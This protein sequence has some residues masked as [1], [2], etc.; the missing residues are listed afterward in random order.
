MTIRALKQAYLGLVTIHFPTLKY[1]ECNPGQLLQE[2]KTSYGVD[3]E[4]AC[5]VY[6]ISILA[7]FVLPKPLGNIKSDTCTQNKSRIQTLN[8]S[9]NIDFPRYI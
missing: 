8:L 1:G 3:L 2:S 6:N 7:P 9:Q 4:E 5:H